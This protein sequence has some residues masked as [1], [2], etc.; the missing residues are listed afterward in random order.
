MKEAARQNSQL[1]PFHKE[2]NQYKSVSNF[3]LDDS[4]NSSK[5]S[6]PLYNS[7]LK[8]KNNFLLEKSIRSRKN[9]GY[10]E[11]REDLRLI[12]KD[13]TSDKLLSNKKYRSKD[14]N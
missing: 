7:N 3:G 8:P 14:N 5:F 4:K 13:P 1:K 12:E 6:Y 9:S 11:D 10:R 2:R